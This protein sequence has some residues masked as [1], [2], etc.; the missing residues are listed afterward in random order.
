MSQVQDL[1]LNAVFSGQ[2]QLGFMA[3]AA[4]IWNNSTAWLQIAGVYVAAP[5]QQ[6]IISMQPASQGPSV[7]LSLQGPPGTA[8]L[9]VFQGSCLVRFTSD[10]LPANPGIQVPASNYQPDITMFTQN[11]AVNGTVV[12]LNMPTGIHSIAAVNTGTGT[13]SFTVK[14]VQTNDLY[15][16]TTISS[17]IAVKADIFPSIDS[18]LLVTITGVSD[19]L[20]TFDLIG[21]PFLSDRN[22]TLLVGSTGLSGWRDATAGGGDTATGA[23]VGAVADW[24]FNDQSQLWERV[25]TDC[26]LSVFATAAGAGAQA[27]STCPAVAGKSVVVTSFTFSVSGLPAAPAAAF[28]CNFGVVWSA[29]N[30]WIHTL[31]IQAVAGDCQTQTTTW[32]RGLR[33][34]VGVA[35]NLQSQAGT[36]GIAN[37]FIAVAGTFHYVDS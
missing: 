3:Q 19:N 8:P 34:P 25:R 28:Q 4:Q 10:P 30:Q 32:S 37:T 7:V 5:N 21:S 27:V 15:L 9:S 14:G 23:G 33:A 17:S 18:Q 26:D 31:A 36:P 24:N 12:T 20:E 16:S 13:V 35:V 29:T 11:P 22:S 6:C 1:N 2:Q